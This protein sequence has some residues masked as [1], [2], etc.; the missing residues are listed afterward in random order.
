MKE[1][2]LKTGQATE[3]QIAEWKEKYGEVYEFTVAN[4]VCYVKKP[5]RKELSAATAVA[6]QGKNID[7]I[8]FSET[9]LNTCFLG[10]DAS[11]KDDDDMFLSILPVLEVLT[12]RAEA[13]V[14]KL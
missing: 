6:S 1:A 10:G 12:Q 8:R 2:E 13:T 9:L 7:P 14:K 4:S 11:I 5:G 3:A